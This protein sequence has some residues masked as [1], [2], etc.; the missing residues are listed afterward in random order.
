MASAQRS[1]VLRCYSCRLFQAHQVKKSRKWTCKACGEKQSLLRTYGEGSGA[2][3]RRHV[4]KLNLL[5]GQASEL[6][7]SCLKAASEVHPSGEGQ[8]QDENASLQGLQGT[9]QQGSSLQSSAHYHTSEL[10][11]PQW[12]P[13]PASYSKNPSSK[14]AR[15]LSS[16]GN[17]SHV[18]TEPTRPLLRS[19]RPACPTHTEQGTPKTETSRKACSSWPLATVQLPQATCRPDGP[20]RKNPKGS[21]DIETPSVVATASAQ[22][23]LKAPSVSLCNLFTTGEDFD[24]DL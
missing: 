21:W 6:P 8:A 12:K 5:Q 7:L 2:E 18:D 20:I 17:S 11:G 10:G 1:R 13:A 9:E 23:T 16:P 4:Q 22:Q 24:D 14:W 15:F 3:C 19:P